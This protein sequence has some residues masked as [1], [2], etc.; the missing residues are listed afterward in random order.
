MWLEWVSFGLLLM[1]LGMQLVCVWL[2]PE[3]REHAN[4]RKLAIDTGGRWVC[5]KCGKVFGDCG[6]LHNELDKRAGLEGVVRVC[7][8][9]GK[10]FM[11]RNEQDEIDTN[12]L[13][14]GGEGGGI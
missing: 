2:C 7:E 5:S 3:W 11:P 6:Q 13:K 9:C 14:V 10:T 4:Y 1:I 8:N 12:P